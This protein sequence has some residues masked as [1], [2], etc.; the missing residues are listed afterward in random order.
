MKYSTIRALDV[1][2]GPGIRVTIF[3]S[4]CNHNCR[5][6]FNQEL[7]DFNHGKEWTKQTEEEFINKVRKPQVAGVSI[8]GG[9]PLEQL[10]DDDL[11]N[12]LSRIKAEMPEKSVWLWTGDIF[13]EA[14]KNADKKRIIDFVDVL[15]DGPFVMEKR[16][17][18]L[19]YRGSENQRVIDVAKSFEAEETVL[20]E[21]V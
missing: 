19:K 1:A 17:L 9:E 14:L 13:E 2:N 10:M 3:V 5:G 18:K 4:G 15:V 6:C 20:V 12:L 7:Q 16:N 11:Y 21:G 8:L